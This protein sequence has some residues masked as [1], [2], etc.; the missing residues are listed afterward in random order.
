MSMDSSDAAA[1][2]AALLMPLGDQAWMAGQQV[3]GVLD[4]D[5]GEGAFGFEE[6]DFMRG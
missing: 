4:V 3:H 5:S 1:A 6:L 2:L